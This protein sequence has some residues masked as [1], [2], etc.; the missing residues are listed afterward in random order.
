MKGTS[1]ILLIFAFVIMSV[2][3]SCKQQSNDNKV[4]SSD[5]I[6]VK[7][8]KKEIGNWEIGSFK[9]EFGEDM[10]VKYVYIESEGKFSNTVA[11]YE[12]VK[13][14][15]RVFNKGLTFHLWDYGNSLLKGD[16]FLTARIKDSKGEIHEMDMDN[17]KDGSISPSG[18]MIDEFLNILKDEGTISVVIKQRYDSDPTL[19]YQFKI[20]ASG[21]NNV[22]KEIF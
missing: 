9:D 21:Y 1:I 18:E 10:G 11:S 13:V 8:T 4:N 5:T 19:N 2:V 17:H 3:S 16:H 6:S 12:Y 22:S 15:L 20:A 14:V 7:E